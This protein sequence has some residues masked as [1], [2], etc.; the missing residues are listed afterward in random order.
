[1]GHRRTRRVRETT[2]TQ[3]DGEVR[4]RRTTRFPFTSPSVPAPAR[5]S[6]RST[7]HP[8]STSAA[9]AR[10]R[11]T[12]PAGVGDHDPCESTPARTR[13]TCGSRGSRPVRPQ[14]TSGRPA[15]RHSSC[16]S[17]PLEAGSGKVSRVIAL[18]PAGSAPGSG[19]GVGGRSPS[20][21]W[22][23]SARAACTPLR[24]KPAGPRRSGPRAATCR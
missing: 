16:S 1:M 15:T 12:V 3:R 24:R 17:A 23:R 11:A 18:A 14:R 6:H 13:S 8:P 7:R 10:H 5:A 19:P 4:S 20:G 22:P 21:G 9:I 2:Y